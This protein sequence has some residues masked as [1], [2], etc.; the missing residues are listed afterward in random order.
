MSYRRNDPPAVS[1]GGLVESTA[2]D[3]FARTGAWPTWFARI[4][5][6]HYK[7]TIPSRLSQLVNARKIELKRRKEAVEW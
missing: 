2:V 3:V 7:G 4:V 1:V 6:T 5:A